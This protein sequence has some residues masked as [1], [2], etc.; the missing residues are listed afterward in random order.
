MATV[1]EKLRGT[2]TSA[3]SQI[4][5][6]EKKAV[7][8]VALLEKRAKASIGEVKESLDDVPGQLKGAWDQVISRVRGALDYASRD[9]LKKVSS[10]VDDLAKKVEKL[11]RGDTIKTVAEKKSTR[12]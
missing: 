9:D 3:K 8:Q 7:K 4:E 1:S 5:G 12:K 6:F 10:K 2:F 11:L